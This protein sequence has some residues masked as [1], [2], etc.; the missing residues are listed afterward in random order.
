VT[1]LIVDD[2]VAVR[3]LVRDQLEARGITVTLAADAADAR[4]ALLHHNFDSIILDI[5]LPDD[6]GLTVLEEL[7]RAGSTA[8]VIMLSGAGKEVDR[9]NALELG[10]D[11]YVVKPFFAR[12]LT[13]RI[14]G[15]RRRRDRDSDSLLIVGHLEIDLEARRVLFR[16]D[17]LE[18]TA[19]EFDLL[20]FLAARP[21]HVFSRDELLRA[22][23]QSAADWQQT[24]TVTE[25]V[26]RLRA[27]IEVDPQR[28]QLLRTVRGVG[29]RLDIP[30]DT[31]EPVGQPDPSARLRHFATGVVSE[32]SDA[33]IV[34][35]LHFHIRSWNH[36]AERLYGWSEHEVTGRH[37]LDVVKQA[38]GADDLSDAWRDLE[39]TDRWFGETQ[40]C[41]RTGSVVTVYSSATVVRD[42][43]GTAIGVVSVNRSVPPSEV[44]EARISRARDEED[45]RRGIDNHE[46]DVWYQP[47]L[48]L[49]DKHVVA[50]E[51][52]VRWNHPRRG[53]LKPV[54]FI[55]TA[56][57]SGLII[58]LGAFVLDKACRQVAEWRRA[59]VDLELAVNLSAKE[60]AD[61]ALP[62]RITKTLE[63]SEL[64]PTALWLEVTET[65]LVEDYD[66]A[67][68][69]LV[70]LAEQGVR[71][72]IDDFGTGWASLTY[73]RRFRVHALK[74]DQT[75]VD[76][77]ET[78]ANDAA[79]VRSILSL[80]AELGLA[81]I[82]EGIETVAQQDFL[83]ALGCAFGQGFL[84]SEPTVAIEV[85]I[86][87]ARGLTP[88]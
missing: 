4:E 13:A 78:N 10:A 57:H 87:R 62:A 52:L 34:T 79:I 45:L 1:T 15:V 72:A 58:E 38:Q 67:S 60:L 5:S 47:V 9:V 30:T 63:T 46:F 44:T 59:N 28:P 16:G 41:T 71:I 86:D 85:P 17:V 43:S 3:I 24:A 26:R 74:I 77:L 73:L 29:Y 12:E 19:K 51:A 21:G 35:D 27:K 7:R 49:S 33:V 31:N 80:G 84:Y 82:A 37:I 32:L 25:H 54:D 65:A 76:G 8:Y 88:S 18:L 2:D 53:V 22:V 61:P 42:E 36:A 6:S 64:T 70:Q 66:Q 81:V 23:W 50:V 14:L 68:D 40:H 69:T 55:T 75:F 11:D 48:A 39:A 56:E 20:A 83:Q